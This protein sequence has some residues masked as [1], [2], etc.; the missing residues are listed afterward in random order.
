MAQRSSNGQAFA[1]KTAAA[2]PRGVHE[3]TSAE[4]LKKRGEVRRWRA[5]AD[6]GGRRRTGPAVGLPPPRAQGYLLQAASAAAWPQPA[7][8]RWLIES[9]DR[10]P[11]RRFQKMRLRPPAGQAH[12]LDYHPSE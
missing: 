5:L 1:A 2:K 12:S 7:D 9:E 8:G 3:R 4:V 10:M 11:E 6:V